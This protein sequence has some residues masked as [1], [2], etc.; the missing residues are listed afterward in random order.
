[1]SKTQTQTQPSAAEAVA[2]ASVIPSAP[3]FYPPWQ[4][5][6]TPATNP[7]GFWTA[8]GHDVWTGGIVM[9]LGTIP[10][11]PTTPQT[12][13]ALQAGYHWQGYLCSGWHS[14]TVRF[15]FGPVTLHQNGGTITGKVY[16]SLGGPL[17][18]PIRSRRHFNQSAAVISK[19]CVYVTINAYLEDAGTYTLR[20]GGQLNSGYSCS[21]N[22]YGE[23]ICS[24]IEVTHCPPSFQAVGAAKG[25]APAALP[26]TQPFKEGEVALIDIDLEKEPRVSLVPGV[27]GL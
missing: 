9:Q 8:V 5:F 1:M 15:Q 7:A 12:W 3:P 14:I 22:P 27:Q 25:V 11:G 24:R 6:R 2:I 26:E 23:I 21:A 10:H 20:L 4:K 13:G 16:A 19:G 17:E 18:F